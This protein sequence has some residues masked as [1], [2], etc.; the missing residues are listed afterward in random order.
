[1]QRKN[2]E[3]SKG[4]ARNSPWKLHSTAVTSPSC[5][6]ISMMVVALTSGLLELVPL[7]LG[8]G[9]VVLSAIIVSV[10]VFVAGEVVVGA[11]VVGRGASVQLVL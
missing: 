11:A 5:S 8:A 4:L 7:L 1:M 3:Q 9:V 10:V 2:L 6:S